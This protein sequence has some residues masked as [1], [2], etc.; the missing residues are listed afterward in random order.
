MEIVEGN[1]LDMSACKHAVEGVDA[2]IHTANLVGALPGMSE[3]EFFDNNV[4]NT[5]NIINVASKRAD[6]LQRL[7]YI[8]SSSVYPNDTHAIAPCYN[9][10]DEMHPLRPEGTYA[11]CLIFSHGSTREKI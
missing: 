8:S 3:T 9:P 5:F 11:H 1:L 2:V 10:I 7:V 4:R 6:S